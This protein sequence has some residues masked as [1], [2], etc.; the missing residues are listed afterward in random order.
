MKYNI[1][2]VLLLIAGA[3]MAI[4][5]D[6]TKNARDTARVRYDEMATP[7]DSTKPPSAWRRY[8]GPTQDEADLEKSDFHKRKFTEKYTPFESISEN[9]VA[10]EENG[11]TETEETEESQG[12]DHGY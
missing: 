11:S 9:T 8:F 4:V 2:L 1:L 3:A 12:Y 10:I 6:F 7:P 5:P